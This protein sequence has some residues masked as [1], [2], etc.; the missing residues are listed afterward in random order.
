[1]IELL[2]QGGRLGVAIGV[3]GAG[4][5]T[6]LAP[7]VDARREDG[8]RVYGMALA[9][10]QT[11]DLARAGIAE[12]DRAAAVFLERAKDGRI[13]L[14]RSSVA[15]IDE[16]GQ[17]GRAAVP[18]LNA[19]ADA[20]PLPSGRGGG[21]EAVPVAGPTIRILERAL[22]LDAIPQLLSRHRQVGAP[23]RPCRLAL[24]H[25]GG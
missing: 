13:A 14:D 25:R 9:W 4:K 18:R 19:L 7:L 17:L 1:M 3:A 23:C 22:G 10:R 8:R 15:V 6:I 20:A 11:D 16:L 2:G 12:G 21:S 5:S 24:I